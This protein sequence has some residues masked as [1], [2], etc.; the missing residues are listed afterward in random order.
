[1]DGSAGLGTGSSFALGVGFGAVDCRSMLAQVLGPESGAALAFFET[2][3][4]A[5][6]GVGSAVVGVASES[7][8][9]VE[10]S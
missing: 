8:Q 5:T 3:A 10:L 6:A 2:A 1:M 4:A 9:A 7:P